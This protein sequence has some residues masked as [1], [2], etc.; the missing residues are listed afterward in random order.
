MEPPPFGDGNTAA[1]RTAGAESRASMEPPPFGDGNA[2]RDLAG[3]Q[4]ERVASME[5]PPFGDGNIVCGSTNIYSYDMLQW[6]H[7]LSAMETLL[8]P[9]GAAPLAPLASMEPP[10]F[11]DG[12][13]AGPRRSRAPCSTRFNGATAFRRWKLDYVQQSEPILSAPLAPLASMEPPP[14]GDGN[15]VNDTVE[16]RSLGLQWSHRLSAME[17]ALRSSRSVGYTM[18][19]WSH[20]LSAMETALRSSRS[21]GYTMLQWSHRLSAMETKTA[22]VARGCSSTLQ[23]SHRL[24]AMETGIDEAEPNHEWVMLQWSH[25]LSAMETA[26]SCPPRTNKDGLRSARMLFDASMEPPPFGDGNT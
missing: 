25:R 21:V 20:R 11:G 7:R 14:F 5:P 1:G 3:R 10:P 13:T 18:L 12:N 17:T 24:S 8:A 15:V 23:W 26:L 2:D 6:S 19:Q 4:H 9:G 22:C 16:D